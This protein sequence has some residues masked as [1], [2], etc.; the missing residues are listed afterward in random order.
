MKRRTIN[1]T[2][3]LG[4]TIIFFI[5]GVMG[6]LIFP[7]FLKFFGIN[8]NSIPKVQIY[9]FH[10][11]LGLIL[12]IIV[13][14]HVDLHR[15]WIIGMIKRSYGKVKVTKVMSKRKM[16]NF[17][18]SISLIISYFLV[19]FTGIIKFPGFLPFIGVSPITIPINE[20]SIIH[21]WSGLI[22]VCLTVIHL[23][24]HV[25]WLISTTKSLLQSIKKSKIKKERAIIIIAIGVATVVTV[26]NFPNPSSSGILDFD[27]FDSPEEKISIS[28]V[29]TFYYTPEN[30]STLR[31]EIFKD[32]HFSVFDIL[33]HLHNTNQIDMKYYF[34]ESMNMYVIDSINDVNNWWYEAYYD[35]GWPENNVF[36]MDHFPYKSK[37]TIKILPSSSSKINKIYE[38][39]KNEVDRIKQNNGKIIIPTV[40][41]RGTKDTLTF[42]NIEVIPHNLRDDMFQE[43]VVTGIDVILTLND[44]D[45]ISYDLQWYDSIGSVEVVRSYWID[46]I[47]EDKARGRCGFVYE[48]GSYHF[49]GF[50]GNHIHLPLDTRVINSP[51]Y[52]EWFWICL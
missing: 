26:F 2:T 34:D 17:L 9:K 35:G 16:T 5:V 41:I 22:A 52:G 49:S 42:S 27:I 8:L 40:I 4:L 18:I 45:L 30:I 1:Y 46:G 38:E 19:I 21:D 36:R 14:I 44:L 31:K 6:I 20:I 7:G 13:S 50:R 32:G 48:L 28:G 24:L 33:F 39:F 3:S 29:G 10:H 25:K 43:G 51:E 15:K 37:M 12:M 47:N 11:W 23:T